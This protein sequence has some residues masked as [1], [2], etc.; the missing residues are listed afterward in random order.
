MAHT[1]MKPIQEDAEE[2][3]RVQRFK[4]RETKKNWI[5]STPKHS[6]IRKAQSAECS[7]S[8]WSETRSVVEVTSFN[9]SS[10]G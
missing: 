9:V 3:N 1:Q 5:S 10:L 6:G 2:I 7:A 4:R 8:G